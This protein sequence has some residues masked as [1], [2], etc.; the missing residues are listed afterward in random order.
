[1]KAN[2]IP[3]EKPW[4]MLRGGEAMLYGIRTAT[5]VCFTFL[6]ACSKGPCVSISH[7]L[8]QMDCMLSDFEIFCQLFGTVQQ[9]YSYHC[10]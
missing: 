7:I 8:T 1:M 4:V 2:G 10:V 3:D 6:K 9:A 5:Y